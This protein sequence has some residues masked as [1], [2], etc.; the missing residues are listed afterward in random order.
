MLVD[1]IAK[2]IWYIIFSSSHICLVLINIVENPM[3]CP[4][5]Y[6]TLLSSISLTRANNMVEIIILLISPEVLDMVFVPATILA[7]VIIPDVLADAKFSTS[8][9]FLQVPLPLMY[10]LP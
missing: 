1:P 3:M 7:D 9:T 5:L 10:L 8:S 2:N 4:I 6:S